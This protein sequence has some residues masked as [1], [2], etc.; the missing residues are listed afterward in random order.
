MRNNYIKII[1]SK[2]SL[3]FYNYFY[4]YKKHSLTFVKE[5]DRDLASWN[6]NCDAVKFF[7]VT[8]AS[9]WNTHTLRYFCENALHCYFTLAEETSLII[10]E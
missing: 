9:A 5:C 1:I 3:I 8:C 7:V 10:A 6:N 4:S 2:K